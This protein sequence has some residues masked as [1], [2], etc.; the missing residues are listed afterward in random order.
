MC[1]I[2]RVEP[3]PDCGD[4]AKGRRTCKRIEMREWL[5]EALDDEIEWR[6][7]DDPETGRFMDLVTFPEPNETGTVF[8]RM[9]GDPELVLG[10]DC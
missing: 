8:I 2:C 4:K 10:S 9:E 6:H 7:A 1:P 3:G 5:H